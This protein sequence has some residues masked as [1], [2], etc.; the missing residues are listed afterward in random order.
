MTATPAQHTETQTT[1]SHIPVGNPFHS[2]KP[3]LNSHYS[4]SNL[5]KPTRKRFTK[6]QQ[7]A[8]V[9]P[10]HVKAIITGKL[11]GDGCLSIL[12]GCTNA[13]LQIHQKDKEFD[14]ICTIALTFRDSGCSSEGTEKHNQTL[15]KHQ[16]LLSILYLFAPL[17]HWATLQC[18]HKVNGRA[19]KV[20]P[21]NIADLLTPRALAYWLSGDGHY[22]KRDGCI[23]L[24]TNSFSPTEVDQLRAALLQN[25]SIESTRVSA[26]VKG[27]DQFIIRIPKREVGKEQTW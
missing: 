24:Y 14:F 13:R 11:L 6:E 20:V 23:Q 1:L 5:G 26:G 8:I 21:C 2:S 27:K 18:Y 16:N 7:A 19:V 17:F 10:T 12:P 15:R 9:F 22:L 4:P 3:C 25:F